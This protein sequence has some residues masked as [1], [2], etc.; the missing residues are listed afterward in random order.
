MG[1]SDV[2]RPT[3][4]GFATYIYIKLIEECNNAEEKKKERS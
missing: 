4:E 3:D 1:D 2:R